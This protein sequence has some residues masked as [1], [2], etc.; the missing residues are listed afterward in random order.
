MIY[1]SLSEQ[2]FRI[3]HK[4]NN[5]KYA[6]YL[7][8][9]YFLSLI[10]K[11]E[12][13]AWIADLWKDLKFQISLTHSQ[14]TSLLENT[15]S[16][17]VLDKSDFLFCL[18]NT[19]LENHYHIFKSVLTVTFKFWKKVSIC[20]DVWKQEGGWN[21]REISWCEHSQILH[22]TL[23]LICISWLRTPRY[24][25]PNPICYSFREYNSNVELGQ[26]SLGQSLLPTT[27]MYNNGFIVFQ[28]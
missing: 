23:F 13:H 5:N 22:L 4:N 14:E 8:I 1:S 15:M 7:G 16:S 18:R 2:S 24:L 28:M 21:K 6:Y 20:L 12:I 26:C 25:I 27:H 3:L 10:L 11:S 17:R 9:F 19:Q